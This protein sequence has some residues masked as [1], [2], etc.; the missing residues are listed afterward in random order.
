M[1]RVWVEKISIKE[2]GRAECEKGETNQLDVYR[3]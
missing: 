2:I 1:E 3:I